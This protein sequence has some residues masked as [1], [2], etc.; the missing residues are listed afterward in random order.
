[1]GRKPKENPKPPQGVYPDGSRSIVL[2]DANAR[3]HSGNR[4]LAI[5]RPSTIATADGTDGGAVPDLIGACIAIREGV[6]IENP[7]TIFTAME[8]YLSLCSMSGMK[9]SNS[10][11]YFACNVTKT[12]VYDWYH[13]RQRKGNPEYKRFAQ[14]V[15]EICSAAR[16]QYGLEGQVNPILTIFH[17][18]YYDGFRD[19]PQIDDVQD[20]MGENQD[21]QKLADKYK[22]I[23][24]D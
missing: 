6:D 13:G 9:I 5:N 23:L 16:E 20:P 3:G 17:Q 2:P 15:K 21:P 14:M 12:M 11:M 7:A 10:M 8:Q 18:K 22:D 4:Q 24:V 19:N 1:M